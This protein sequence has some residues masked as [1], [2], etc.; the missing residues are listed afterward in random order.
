MDGSLPV[1]D[2]VLDCL[3]QELTELADLQPA[4]RQVRLL[5]TCLSVCLQ[6]L[7]SVLH[8]DLVLRYVKTTM[9]TDS[10]SREQ[11]G[12]GAQQIMEDSQKISLFPP[13]R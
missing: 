9:K 7:L 3:N 13:A 10:K 2:S 1:V 5:L 4:C 6:S 11:Q 12:G 8:Q